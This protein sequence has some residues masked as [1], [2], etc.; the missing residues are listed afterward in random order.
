MQN[1]P[2][3]KRMNTD[4]EPVTATD[5]QLSYIFTIHAKTQIDVS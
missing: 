3:E 1:T 5:T 4:L 2:V